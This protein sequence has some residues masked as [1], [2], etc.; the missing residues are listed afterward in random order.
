MDT[1]KFLNESKIFSAILMIILNLGGRHLMMEI[2]VEIES[3]F[4]NPIIRKITLFSI[5]FMATKDV[6]LSFI[7]TI[8]FSIIFGHLLNR[9]SQMCL[10]RK[11][12]GLITKREYESA[13]NIIKIWKQ[14]HM[15]L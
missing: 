7:V 13:L 11:H 15:R 9:R 4:A 8:A 1:L 5:V 10:I 6:I 14:Q 12:D 2:P 3:I